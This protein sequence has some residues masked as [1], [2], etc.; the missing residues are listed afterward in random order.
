MIM[1]DPSGHGIGAILI[2][3]AGK[4]REALPPMEWVKIAVVAIVTSV[5]TSTV[6]IARL[7][8]RIDGLRIERKIIVE[9]RDKQT[10]RIEQR[11]DRIEA[12]LEQLKR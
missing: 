7:E 4:V 12:R 3:F 10:R 6:T 2:L 1:L 8:E 9:A 5:L 11:L